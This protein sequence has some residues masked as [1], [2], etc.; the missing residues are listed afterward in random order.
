MNPIII[1][2][3]SNFD[4][5]TFNIIFKIGLWIFPPLIAIFIFL[6]HWAFPSQFLTLILQLLKIIFDLVKQ[7]YIQ[8]LKFSNNLITSLFFLIIFI[9]L[10]GLIPYIFSTS[11]HLRIT[12]TISLPLWL[13]LI[14]SSANNNPYNFI[15]A[16][17][18]SGAPN[19]LNPFLVIIELIRTNIRPITLAFRLAANMRAGHIVITLIRT[20]LSNALFSVRPTII[21][22][23]IPGVFYLLFEL[24]ISIIQA[25][26]FC[27]LITLYSNDHQ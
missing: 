18:P 3:F 25:F 10:W 27:L 19:W 13:A 20:Y 7:T 4:P 1:D 22:Y 14:V 15:A 24:F 23:L 5:A 9:N 12:L 2:I 6:S 11:T 26:I 17:V 8:N 21:F 16:I